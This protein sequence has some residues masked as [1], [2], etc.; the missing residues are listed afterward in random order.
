MNKH[1]INIIIVDNNKDFCNILNDYLSTQED[2]VVTGIANNGINALKLIEIK[3]P[4]LVILDI[5][6]PILNGL[7]VLERLNATYLCPAPHVIVLSSVSQDRIMERAISLGADTYIIKP[8]NLELFLKEIR[9]ILNNSTGND[10]VKKPLPHIC[11]NE[12]K[13][14][15]NQTLAIIA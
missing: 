6:M 12:N 8:F 4:D 11:K 5:V 14:N 1:K 10:N 9:N 7:E 2:I 15:I 3:K 13:I